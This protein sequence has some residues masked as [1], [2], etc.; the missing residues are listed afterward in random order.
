MSFLYISV[1]LRVT[2]MHLSLIFSLLSVFT[3]ANCLPDH[4]QGEQFLPADAY[5]D[6]RL[7][8]EV[9]ERAPGPNA[10]ADPNGHERF[11]NVHNNAERQQVYFSTHIP[12]GSYY[13]MKRHHQPIIGSKR[14]YKRDHQTQGE[15]FLPADAYDDFRLPQEV[16]ERAPG[17]NAFANPEFGHERFQNVHNNAQR[18]EVYF[19][20]HVPGGSYYTMK[21]HHQPIIGSKR[22]YKRDHSQGEQFLPA[23]SYNDFRLPKE[24]VERAPGPNAFAD[25]NGFERFQNVHNNAERQQIY[26]S[27]HDPSGS[28]YTMKAN[29]RPIVRQRRY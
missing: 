12:G 3:V 27:T 5:D 15:Q 6:F 14:R 19:S 9:H 2:K 23:D 20:T 21:R 25:P 22:R 16:V 24:V 1:G 29:H 18:Q 8:Q 7:P 28:Y 26:F 13:T 10:F 17:P 4:H 11:Q